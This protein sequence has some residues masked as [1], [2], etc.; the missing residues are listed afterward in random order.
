MTPPAQRERVVLVVDDDETIRDALSELLSEEGYLVLTA[1]N[2]QEALAELRQGSRR[3]PGLIL[4]DMMMPVM[5]G[6]EFYDQQQLDPSLMD[7]PV[8]IM[9]AD[10]N[11]RERAASYGGSYLA[12]PARLE[13]ILEMV[14][15]HCAVGI[16]SSTRPRG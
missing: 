13:T 16:N 14:G 11:L 4:L 8:V 6:P 15:R 5:N 7:I 12:K 2:G 3:R 10:R 9:S 1:R